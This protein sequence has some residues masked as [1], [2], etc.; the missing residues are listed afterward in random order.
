MRLDADKAK[1]LAFMEAIGNRVGS[2]GTIYLTGV[3]T[4]LLYG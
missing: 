3:A 1:L 2:S 4:A